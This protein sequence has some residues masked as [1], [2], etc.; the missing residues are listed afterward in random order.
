M[1]NKILT[2]TLYFFEEVFHTIGGIL[3]AFIRQL[4]PFAVPAS[5]AFFLA[6]AVGAA[7]DALEPGWGIWVGVI[8]ALGLESAGIL[9]AHYAVKY[10]AAGDIRWQLATAATI[11]YLTIGIAT[12]WLLDADSAV[13]VVGTAMFLIAAIVYLLVGMAEADRVQETAVSQ[14]LV[15]D[16]E[17]A[18]R[19]HAHQHELAIMD[20][21]LRHEEKLAR[22]ASKRQD[23]RQDAGILPVSS[24]KIPDDWRQLTRQQ[25]HHLA[26]LPREERENAMPE[27]ADR[28]RRAWHSRLDEIAAQNGSYEVMK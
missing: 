3:L 28:T 22:L 17:Q 2:Q 13:R 11:A 9:A 16:A 10:Y 1:A 23:A 27:L 19:E 25:K 20:R 12:I 8:A 4:A 6:H 15:I 24:G 7:A 5:P 26:H 18:T 21:Q 14:R